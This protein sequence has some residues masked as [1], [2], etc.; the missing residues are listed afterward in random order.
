MKKTELKRMLKEFLLAMLGI[1]L[2]YFIPPCLTG[3]IEMGFS[4]ASRSVVFFGSFVVIIIILC[5]LGSYKKKPRITRKN[6]YYVRG[7]PQEYS[8]AVASFLVRNSFNETVDIPATI[9]S[10]IGKSILEYKDKNITSVSNAD[11]T[12]LSEHEKYLYWCFSTGTKISPTRVQYLVIEDAVKKGYIE[13]IKKKDYLKICAYIIGILMGVTILS[14]FLVM[15]FDF[16]FIIIPIMM[17]ATFF[18][19]LSPIYFSFKEETINKNT[20]KNTKLGQ[21]EL[22]NLLNLKDYLDEFSNFKKA[23]I[24][25]SILW[26]D[27]IAY[28]YIFNIN[29]NLYD[30]FEE[31]KQLSHLYNENA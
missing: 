30:E 17:F 29:K 19:F 2:F 21:K 9:L 8:V 7:V 26:E 3:D 15:I 12:N 6:K 4:F 16:L 28:A 14:S 18:S 1:F 22:K 20:Y 10:L 5:I 25:E 13:E 31:I 23:E 24:E 11:L 27:Y